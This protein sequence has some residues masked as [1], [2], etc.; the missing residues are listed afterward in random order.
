MDKASASVA[1]VS[2]LDYESN[3]PNDFK[4]GVGLL[5]F[6][7]GRLVLQCGEQAGNVT[8]CAVG[9]GTCH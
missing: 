6:P 4:M 3:R 1:V 2:G 8:F 5:S 7:A 9:K